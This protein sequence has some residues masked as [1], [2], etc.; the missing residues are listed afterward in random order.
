M[1]V[2]R[3]RLRSSTA[4]RQQAASQTALQ[5]S[6]N[7]TAPTSFFVIRPNIESSLTSTVIDANRIDEHRCVSS[8][9]G[10][11]IDADSRQLYVSLREQMI[12]ND[13]LLI[14]IVGETKVAIFK[15]VKLTSM[16]LARVV[17]EVIADDLGGTLPPHGK[18]FLQTPNG[19]FRLASRPNTDNTTEQSAHLQ[20]GARTVQVFGELSPV[21]RSRGWMSIDELYQL[22]QVTF[23]PAEMLRKVAVRFRQST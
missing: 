16:R 8:S 11:A 22:H 21:H 15:E 6:Q 20:L 1:G 13:E 12:D 23:D 18:Q 14:T 2:T 4:W 17:R 9:A 3:S 19:V 5:R 10:A 7:A